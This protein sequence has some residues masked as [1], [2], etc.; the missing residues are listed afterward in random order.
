MFAHQ[1]SP[2]PPELCEGGDLDLTPVCF[3]QNTKKDA[4]HSRLEINT[5]K[6][7]FLCDN[8]IKFWS[9]LIQ[10]RAHYVWHPLKWTHQTLQISLTRTL[11]RTLGRV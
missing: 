2:K 3:S 5:R 11:E 10:S 8:Y 6:K 9:K 1:P 4:E 7:A